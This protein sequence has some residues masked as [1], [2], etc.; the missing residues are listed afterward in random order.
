MDKAIVI[1]VTLLNGAQKD[2]D[3]DVSYKF[4]LVCLA[5]FPY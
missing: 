4:L 3:D 1:S 5:V 2:T